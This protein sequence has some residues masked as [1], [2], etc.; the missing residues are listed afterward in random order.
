MDRDYMDERSLD[1]ELYVRCWQSIEHLYTGELHKD[2]IKFNITMILLA[3][4]KKRCPT[5]KNRTGMAGAVLL[6]TALHLLFP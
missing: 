3:E 5:R 4:N 2:G 6:P 1:R